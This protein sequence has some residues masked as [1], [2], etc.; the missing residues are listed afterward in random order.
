MEDAEFKVP[1]FLC[2]FDYDPDGPSDDL[3]SC[4]T[5]WSE[6]EQAS[7]QQSLQA[8]QTQYASERAQ[9]EALEREAELL[10]REN[11]TLEQQLAG[12]EGCEVWPCH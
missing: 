11:A 1:V 3:E 10:A 5:S 12:M 8:L 6:E 2:R 7:L 9:R 4:D